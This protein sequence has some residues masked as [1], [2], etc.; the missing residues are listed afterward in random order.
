MPTYDYQC[1]KCGALVEVEHSVRED[2]VVVADTLVC[3]KGCQWAPQET[4]VHFKRLIGGGAF[5]LKGSGW[6]RDGYK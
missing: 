6:S 4:G 1:T 5:S 3:P 2:P